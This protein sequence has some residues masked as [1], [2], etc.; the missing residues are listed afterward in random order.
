MKA[1]QITICI[2]III[3]LIAVLFSISYDKEG[4]RGDAA[5][6][7][8]SPQK[9]VR[10]ETPSESAYDSHIDIFHRNGIKT[11]EDFHKTLSLKEYKELLDLNNKFLN[12]DYENKKLLA[13]DG[14]VPPFSIP[15]DWFKGRYNHEKKGR[16][17][18]DE[19]LGPW[20]DYESWVDTFYNGNF[21]SNGWNFY[22]NKW[23]NTDLAG[24]DAG[25][26]K[27]IDKLLEEK[28]KRIAGDFAFK[29]PK[30]ATVQWGQAQ[31]EALEQIATG[32]YTD[33]KSKQQA[34]KD[35][36]D[37]INKELDAGGVPPNSAITAASVAAYP[38]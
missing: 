3:A 36:L 17:P 33:M 34:F 8:R 11:F 9:E 26:H 22:E 25:L 2:I 29:K 21:L 32:T 18:C 14:A 31:L 35:K 30:I 27:Q 13:V 6:I 20:E 7:S 1:E 4:I 12:L 24:G 19:E 16:F 15:F 10:Q 23:L 37:A 28:G 38:C 5:S